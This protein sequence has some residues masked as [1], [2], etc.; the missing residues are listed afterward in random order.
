M[1]R[2]PCGGFNIGDGLSIDPVTRTLSALGGSSSVN[3][4]HFT[5]DDDYGEILSADKTVSEII[6]NAFIGNVNIGE[7]YEFIGNTTTGESYGLDTMGFYQLLYVMPAEGKYDAEVVFYRVE[8][9]PSFNMSN[10]VSGCG[11]LTH[12][13]T[14]TAKA[15]GDVWKHYTNELF[16]SAQMG[17]VLR[18]PNKMFELKVDDT[19]SISATELTT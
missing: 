13:I 15:S 1:N 19:G 16:L 3:T 8:S 5:W 4:I 2:I 18:S 12:I 11:L 17:I 7:S 6:G 14:G 9:R 10:D